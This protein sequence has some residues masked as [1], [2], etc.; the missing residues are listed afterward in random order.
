MSKLKSILNK[1]ISWLKKASIVKAILVWVV[2]V[3]VLA[4]VVDKIALPVF[5]GHFASTGVVPNLEGLDSATVEKT[6]D[7]AGFKCEWL[8]EGRYSV[9]VPAGMVLVQMPAAGRVAKLGRTVKLTKSLGVREVEI[10]DLR[11]KSQK[12]AEITL[13][14]AGL[15][16]GEIVKGAHAS[17]PRG[18]VIRT[19]PMAGNVVRMGDTVKVVISA[20][21]TTGKVMLPSF[22]GE[23][24]D[25]VYPK[26]EKLGFQVGKIKR[27][28]GENGERP[29][30]VL[31]TAPKEGDY[32]KPDTKI[33]FII[34]D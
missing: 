10:P 25:D 30:T 28:K 5:S 9:Q 7:S 21:V 24:M 15:V 20:G 12:Q 32:L 4:F 8:E 33:D 22:E 26:L 23:V 13:T 11:G 16:Q 27:V 6:L 1:I 18:V 34:V 2:L 19:E 29:G 17:I 31:E 3:I 14:R